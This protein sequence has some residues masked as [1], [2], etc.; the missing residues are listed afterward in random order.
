MEAPE[1]HVLK[2]IPWQFFGTLTFKQE[3]LPERIRLSVRK[4]ARPPGDG[5]FISS[6]QDCPQKPAPYAPALPSKTA[7]KPSRAAWRV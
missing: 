7:G 3:R 1:I 2:E 4:T 6:S 5:I